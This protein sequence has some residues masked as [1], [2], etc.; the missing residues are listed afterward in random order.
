MTTDKKRVLLGTDL[1]GSAIILATDSPW[2]A[3]D[4]EEISNDAE[5]IGLI[6]GKDCPDPG[7]YLWEGEGR[8]ENGNSEY[9][10]D[11][12]YTGTIRPVAPDEL[13]ALYAMTPPEDFSDD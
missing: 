3:F 5:E 11:V 7:L 2:V 12:I 6:N 8:L 9:G 13:A 1:H 4:C 10:P